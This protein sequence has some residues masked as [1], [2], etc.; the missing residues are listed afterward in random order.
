MHDY[1]EQVGFM[2]DDYSDMSGPTPDDIAQWADLESYVWALDSG[3]YDI[4][5][6]DA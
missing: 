1:L 2:C 3:R 6:E 5:S 4:E